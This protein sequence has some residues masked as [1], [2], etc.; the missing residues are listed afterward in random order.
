M[1]SESFLHLAILLTLAVPLLAIVGLPI[2]VITGQILSIL[3]QRTAYDKCAKQITKLC[4]ILS[5]A[6]CIVGLYILWLR[7]GP[8]IL[9]LISQSSNQIIAENT[10]TQ[11]VTWT[12]LLSAAPSVVHIQADIIL[13][14][15]MLGASLLMTLA[16]ILWPTWEEKRLVHQSLSLVSSFWYALVV[17][18]ILCIISAEHGM[19][20]GITYPQS[21]GKLFSPS[22]ES[23]F[24][25]SALYFVP[26][27]FALSGGIVSVWL[28][29]RRNIDDF[30]R[31]YYAITLKWCAA[32]ARSAWFALWFLLMGTTAFK[33]I[34]SLKDE[35]YLTSPEFLHGALFLL[36]WLIPGILWTLV[37]R[38]ATPLRHKMT[39]ILAFVL[40]MCIVVPLYMDLVAV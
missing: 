22:L 27:A 25:N 15:T 1:N 9:E 34:N 18:G 24:W 33:W 30:G 5:F 35:N 20:V 32:W 14:L 38:S 28:I 26:F 21:L 29:I 8:I 36:L 3:R 2:M 16:Y 6:L 23:S 11:N 10:T 40:G 19:A 37:T 7:L 13:W 4:L 17:Y 12:L 31:D 39:L